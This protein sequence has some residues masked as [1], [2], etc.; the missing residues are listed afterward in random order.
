MTQTLVLGLGNKLLSDEG[1]G[2]VVVEQLR[3]R[4]PAAAD[5][6]CLDG[7]TLSFVLAGDIGR[8]DN[9]IVVDAAQFGAPPGT[10][11][12]LTGND[13]DRFLGS[14]RRSVHEVGLL[15]LMDIARL[16]ETLPRNRALVGI[17]PAL[18]DWGDRPTAV[19]SGAIPVAVG[20]ID[21][22]IQR[23]RQEAGR[24]CA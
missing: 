1:I 22:L 12:C 20:H 18:V 3:R 19:V 4:A 2:L 10:V 9:L 23:W 24:E 7:G 13:M 6:T 17:Q 5:V 16:T 11:R 15:D 21:R 8:A 14:A